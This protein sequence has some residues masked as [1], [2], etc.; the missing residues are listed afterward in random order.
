MTP[1]RTTRRIVPRLTRTALW[2]CLSVGA[3]GLVGCGS[4]A[5]P[6]D[7]SALPAT[8]SPGANDPIWLSSRGSLP[9]PDTERI[10]YDAHKRLLTL[11]ELPGNNRW[12]VQLPDEENGRFVGPMHVLPEGVDTA[13][14]LVYYARPGFKA[15]AP[16]TVAQIESGRMPHTSQV[17]NP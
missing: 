12:M 6:E 3:L 11:H 14:T 2:M 7:T 1:L 8:V 4:A 15:S 16:V 17:R 10:E 9:A 5:V 13:R